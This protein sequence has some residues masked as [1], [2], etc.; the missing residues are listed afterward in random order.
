MNN[1]EL[2][3]LRYFVAGAEEGH[4]GRAAKRLHMAQP[5]LSRQIHQLESELGVQL[6]R[7]D[8]RG[9][10]L[11]DAGS[12]LLP[13][14]RSTLAEVER[15]V[16]IVQRVSSG[17]PTPLRIGYGWSAGFEVLPMLGQVL[18]ERY[19]DVG[20]LAQEM[21]NAQ[22]G[23]ALLAGEIDVAV[24][25]NP[26]L[27]PSLGYET[28]R[29]ETLVAIVPRDHALAG[30]RLLL[31][32]R[33]WHRDCTIRCLTSVDA[34]GSSRS[35]STSPFI[36]R[37]IW[38]C[39]RMRLDSVSVH[40]PPREALQPVSRLCVCRPRRRRCRRLCSGIVSL[41]VHA[42]RRWWQSYAS[43]RRLE[44]GAPSAEGEGPVLA[45]RM[46]ITDQ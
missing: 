28:I 36:R 46:G 24:T 23:N 21:W 9:V 31:F 8:R 22:L 33:S 7:R 10:E 30:E 4:V 39:R 29:D 37:G 1:I 11:T 19:P 32:P 18:R 40:H 16:S 20:F 12:A 43:L 6:F 45:Y 25:R 34:L 41:R 44:R 14:A 15:A 17:Q 35:R 27:L 3:Q 26:D 2:R 38:A 13:L 42:W 5:P